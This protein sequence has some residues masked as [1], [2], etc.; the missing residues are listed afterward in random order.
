ML[1]GIVLIGF[2][3]WPT[4]TFAQHAAADPG[5]GAQRLWLGVGLGSA[6][7]RSVAPAPAAGRGAVAASLDIGYRVTPQW[8]LGLEFGTVAPVHG[9]A[10]VNCSGTVAAFAPNISRMFAFGEFRPQHSGWRLRAG[11]GVSNFCYRRH[12]APGAWSWVD[13]LN[14]LLNDQ[15]INNETVSGSGAYRC[16]ARNHALGGALS[17]GYDRPA[18]QGTPLSMGLRL[19][20]EAANFGAT[21]AVGLPAFRHR[22]LMLT[23]QLNIN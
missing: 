13:T 17:L 10:D 8:G 19:S 6:T 14:L 5:A 20:A 9:C 3:G 18:A 11:A 1:V 22:A 7:V 16:D 12:W 21:P 4:P 23:L 15:S 2:A